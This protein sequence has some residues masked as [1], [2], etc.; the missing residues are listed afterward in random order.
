[1]KLELN[2]QLIF[3]FFYVFSKIK[4][5]ILRKYIKKNLKKDLLR[6]FNCQQDI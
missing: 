6:N 5:E 4:L 1:M 2:K 3:K